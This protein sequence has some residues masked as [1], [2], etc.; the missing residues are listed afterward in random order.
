MPET[1]TPPV[2]AAAPVRGNRAMVREVLAPLRGRSVADIGCGDGLWTRFLTLEGARVVGLDP[3]R[4]QLALACAEKRVGD[5][6]YVEAGAEALPFEA[7][8]FD[9]VLFFKSLHHVPPDLMAQALS[10]AAR[11][12]RPRG[13]MAAFEPVAR[14]ANYELNRP[15]DDEAEVRA[16]AYRC[17]GA[18]A[19]DDP[20]LTLDRELEYVTVSH[21]RDFSDWR[22]WQVSI[23]PAR[24]ARF[25]ADGAA[26]RAHFD[27]IASTC[28][29][30]ANGAVVL[31]QPM[32]VMVFR[33]LVD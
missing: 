21:R 22:D 9:I 29:R 15:V 33:R 6:V 13:V 7:G 30:D 1:A 8:R 25:E 28:S 18:A 20:R 11:V 17:L 27:D 5:E 23:N 32:R 24:A 26:L 16:A 12:V 4:R 3:N 31:D 10:E 14:G 19:A 2:S